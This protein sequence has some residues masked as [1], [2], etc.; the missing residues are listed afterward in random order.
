MLYAARVQDEFSKMK[1]GRVSEFSADKEVTEII[2]KEKTIKGLKFLREIKKI[3]QP[4]EVAF[5]G[6]SSRPSF[7]RRVVNYGNVA[8]KK[9]DGII[10]NNTGMMGEINNL[11]ASLHQLGEADPLIKNRLEF[12]KELKNFDIGANKLYR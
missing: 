1:Q 9:A 5:S 8:A 4:D 2:G 7:V 12:I 6:A 3:P 11:L 10:P